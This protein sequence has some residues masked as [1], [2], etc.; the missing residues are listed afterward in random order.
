[1]EKILFTC[2]NRNCSCLKEKLGLYFFT[3]DVKEAR[4]HSEGGN[5]AMFISKHS[6]EEIKGIYESIKVLS[7]S[8]T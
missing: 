4:K 5:S 1:M 3:T 8:S 2:A 7:K 6:E